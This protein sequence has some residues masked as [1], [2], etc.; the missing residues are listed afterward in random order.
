M[1]KVFAAVLAV[2]MI[3]FG[4][5]LVGSPERLEPETVTRE[6]GC[7]RVDTRLSAELVMDRLRAK[8]LWRERFDGVVVYYAYSDYVR[9][10]EVVHSQRVNVMIA[11]RA[12]VTAVGMPLLVGSY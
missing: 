3:F 6:G 12:E 7:V 11:E 10:Y 2:F 8:E 9:G 1:K 5:S 4:L